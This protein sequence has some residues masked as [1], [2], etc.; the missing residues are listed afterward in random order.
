M[1]TSIRKKL[2]E[3]EGLTGILRELFPYLGLLLMIVLFSVTTNG[4]FFR[5]RNLAMI[6]K[7]S[8]IVMIGALGSSFVLAHGNMDFSI[9]GE[10]ALCC[11]LS[12]YV[13]RL[14]PYLMLPACI[15]LALLLSFLVGVVHVVIGVPAFVSG[16]CVMFIGKGIVQSVSGSGLICPSIYNVLDAT[17]FYVLALALALAVTY[18]L[19][20]Y[21]R[22]GRNNRLI[23][24]NPKAAFLSGID[25]KKYKILAFLTSGFCVGIS[26]FLTIIRGGGISA[27]TGA[28]FEMD[29]IIVLT[30]GGAP[31][32]G[33][34]GVRL[35][36]ALLGALTYFI[37]SNGLII[38]G[39][40]AEIIFAIKGIL[41][42]TI[43]ALT[44]DRSNK[45]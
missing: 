43:V 27:Q 16:M 41:F 4:K 45:A 39:V 42:L 22:I 33:G 26:S 6:L 35:R 9:G 15:L 14:N 7:Q 12:Y 5:I 40:P 29:T 30:L 44:F 32:S 24:S 21:T 28:S 20:N 8:V 34:S 10:M 38:W 25:T 19:F 2:G 31:L 17:W 37:L 3:K 11:L 36:S 23:G 13:S 1:I 18:I